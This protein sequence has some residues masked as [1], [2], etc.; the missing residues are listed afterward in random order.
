[1]IHHPQIAA[2]VEDL[3]LLDR[4]AQVAADVVI[5]QVAYR[6]VKERAGVE[7]AV[8][9]E[10][11]GRPWMSLAPDLRITFTTVPEARPISASWLVK[12]TSTVWMASIGGM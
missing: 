2:E 8:L 10:F 9:Q 11:V 5:R 6:R 7:V 3:V 1:M 4:S 12:E